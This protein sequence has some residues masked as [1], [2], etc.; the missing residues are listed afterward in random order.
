M[1]SHSNQPHHGRRDAGAAARTGTSATTSGRPAPWAVRYWAWVAS[2][3]CDPPALSICCV[4]WYSSVREF[5]DPPN[6]RLGQE[7]RG[8]KRALSQHPRTNQLLGAVQAKRVR[9]E[10]FGNSIRRQQ[11]LLGLCIAQAGVDGTE[12]EQREDLGLY[13][14]RA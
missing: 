8:K 4:C 11:H 7:R 6:R 3:V 12:N 13:P 9:A 1:Y 5:K 10:L 2:S 14:Q